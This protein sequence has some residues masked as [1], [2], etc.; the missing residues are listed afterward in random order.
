MNANLLFDSA[1]YPVRRFLTLALLGLASQA[2]VAGDPVPSSRRIDWTY[3]G[4]PGGIPNRTNVCATFSPG[5]TASAINSALASCSNGV[6][7]LNAGTYNITGINVGSN[8]VTLR[9]A[10]A[11]Q[12]ILRGCN[13]TSLGKGGNLSSGIAITGGAAKDSRTFTVASTSGLAAGTMI[14]IDRDNESFVVSTV[15]GSRHIRQVNVITAVNGNTVTVRNPL[16]WDF[17]AGNP[18]IKF[19]YINTRGSGIEDMKLDHSGTSGCTN[20]MVQYCD[21]CWIKGV[22][23]YM[24]SGY[25][26][27]IVGSVNGEF[28]DNYVG[29]AQTYGANNAGTAFYG[30][31]SYGSNS[32]WK[33]ENNIFNKNFPAIELQNSSSGFYVGY[34]YSH[35]S[36]AT[37][38]N[39]PVTW[40][41]MDNHGPH[42][43]MNLWE[44]NVGEMFGSDGYYGGSSHGTAF[45]NHLTGFNRNSGAVDEPV[46]LNRLSYYYNIVGNVLGSSNWT[47]AKYSQNTDGCSGGVGIYRIGYPN[48]GSCSLTDDAGYPVAGMSYPDARVGSTLLRWGNFD[49]A[50]RASRFLASELPSGVSAPAD[51]ALP[52]SYYYTSRPSWFPAAVAW[53]PIGPEV[54]GGTAF[55]D[56]TGRVHKIPAALCWENRN[57]AS[58]GSFNAAACYGSQGPA[59]TP[60]SAPTGLRVIN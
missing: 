48:I 2:V 1:A 30:N 23:S 12:T 49:Y 20:F 51:Q 6:V 26:F 40:T 25:H 31:P 44:G 36:A 57:L 13:I 59:G 54:T 34:N 4:V 58:G 15:G 8:N 35:G 32:S 46:R 43:M 52:A 17:T 24:P 14:E 38:T 60:L 9:G 21:S 39:A 7:K 53:P 45:R 50:S 55:G 47:A 3:A 22:E 28:R 33:V 27:V 56:S 16:I 19:T 37:A 18:K 5:A 29:A 41:F 10:G 11:D 42:N